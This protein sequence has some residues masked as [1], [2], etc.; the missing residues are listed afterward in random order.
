MTLPSLPPFSVRRAA[1]LIV[2]LFSVLW[3]AAC[4][5][6]PG[7]GSGGPRINTSRPVPVALL[8]PAGSGQPGDEALARSLENAA[9]LAMA[10]LDG[11]EIDLRVYATAGQP[12]TAA[13]VARQAVDDGARILLGPVYSGA[14]RAAGEAVRPRGVNVLAF[15]NNTDIAGGN[16][17]VLGHTFENTANRLMRFAAAQGKSSLVIVHGQS[18]AE[19]KGRDAFAAAAAAAGVEVRGIFPFELSQTGVVNAV[20]KIAEMIRSTGAQSVAFTSGT[21]GALPILTQL[22]TENGIDPAETQF[23]GLQR[24]D[25]PRSALELPGLQ[26]GWFAIPDPALMQQFEARY[27]EAYGT[28]PHPIAGLA[29]DGIAAIGALVKA[30][31]SDALAASGLTQ[32]SGFLGVNGVFRL[33]GDGTVERALAVAT[34]RDEEV[35][36]LDPAPRSFGGAGI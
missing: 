5:V 14:A 24:W 31:K 27:A 36:V 16:V 21:A 26:N 4:D 8:V 23:I 10:D 18:P 34:I 6:A 32:P 22:L 1:G 29:Y 7:A 33:R 20:P 11:V 15:S 2:A 13:E 35:V 25:I 17:F 12:A 28:P 9:R 3:L 30:G 19:E